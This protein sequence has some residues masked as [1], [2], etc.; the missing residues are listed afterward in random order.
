MFGSQRRRREEQTE[1]VAVEGG[2]KE[3]DANERILPTTIRA[4]GPNRHVTDVI[5]V[6]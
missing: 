2:R 6:M 1:A 3:F 5:L 4:N